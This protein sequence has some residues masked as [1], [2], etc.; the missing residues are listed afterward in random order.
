MEQ[1]KIMNGTTDK[2][3]ERSIMESKP[4]VTCKYIEFKPLNFVL[5]LTFV[6][7]CA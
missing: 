4:I 7:S 6:S 3:T 5:R 1:L 2:T